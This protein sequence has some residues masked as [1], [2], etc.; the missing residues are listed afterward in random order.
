MVLT[1]VALALAIAVALG[2]ARSANATSGGTNG[3]IAFERAGNIWTMNANGTGQT[4]ITTGG[5]TYAPSWRPDGKK[6]AYVRPATYDDS[7]V[8]VDP[9]GIEVVNADGSGSAQRVLEDPAVMSMGLTWS[10]NCSRIAYGHADDSLDGVNEHIW[11]LNVTSGTSTQLTTGTT[12]D[13]SPDWSPNGAKIA[14]TSTRQAGA[15]A[16]GSTNHLLYAMNSDGTGVSRLTTLADP[17]ASLH[18]RD[19]SWKPDGTAIV[20][21]SD[22]DFGESGPLGPLVVVAADGSIRTALTTTDGP[23]SGA[24]PVWSPD[25]TKIVVGSFGQFSGLQVYDVGAQTATALSSGDAEPDWVASNG[26]CGGSTD[27]VPPTLTLPANFGVDA[28][29]PGGANVPFTATATD[30]VAPA[31]SVTC[32]PAALSLFPI[33]DTTVS[34]TAKDAAGNTA[35]G[36]FT[37]HVRG[38]VEQLQRLAAKILAD[39]GIALRTRSTLAAQIQGFVAVLARGVLPP[40][41]TCLAMSIGLA[42]VRALPPFSISAASRANIVADIQRIRAVLGC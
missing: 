24:N 27:T 33:G 28:T 36:T 6:I 34:C 38:A 4:Q 3:K 42:E 16:N 37:I 15:T 18:E 29:S 9:G 23:F 14:F 5:N 35:T 13:R 26:S 11:A 39:P 40:R 8:M 21:R 19:P 41:V 17:N 10:P 25:G 7:G 2:A 22:T 12:L 32:V 20:V 31:P 30:N 1:A